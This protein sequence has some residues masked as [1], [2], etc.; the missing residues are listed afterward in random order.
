MADTVLYRVFCE[1]GSALAGSFTTCRVWSGGFSTA[2]GYTGA[3]D[4]LP[5]CK[6]NI[7][8]GSLA[9][10]SRPHRSANQRS[11]LSP[12]SSGATSLISMRYQIEMIDGYDSGFA[13][14]RLSVDRG[15]HNYVEYISHLLCHHLFLC[16]P[17]ISCFP[18]PLPSAIAIPLPAVFEFFV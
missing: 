16:S 7:S 4:S 8:I 18:F 15:K 9:S 6:H 10:P 5:R 3:S 12:F 1:V 11:S 13:L 14:L 17:S 2:S